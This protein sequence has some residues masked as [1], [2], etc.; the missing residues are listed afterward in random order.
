MVCFFQPVAQPSVDSSNDQLLQTVKVD[1]ADSNVV[2][3]TEESE[4]R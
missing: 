3:G 1:G 2:L 4:E